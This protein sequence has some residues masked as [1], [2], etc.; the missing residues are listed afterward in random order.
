MLA[1]ST[2]A[3]RTSENI[4]KGPN[5]SDTVATGLASRMRNAHETIPPTKDDMTPSP[6]A[7]PGCPF[8]AM[9]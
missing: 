9:G 2:S 4:S 6:S 3:M 8:F 7:R 5:S 1:I